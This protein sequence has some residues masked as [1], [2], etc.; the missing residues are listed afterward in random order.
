MPSN[1]SSN[2]KTQQWALLFLALGLLLFPLAGLI[3]P[4]WWWGSHHLAFLPTGLVAGFWGVA[5]G[6]I[7]VAMWKGRPFLSIPLTQPGIYTTI[8]LLVALLVGFLAYHFPLANDPYGDAFLYFPLREIGAERLDPDIFKKVFSIDFGSGQGRQALL[9][10]MTI[11]TYYTGLTYK[12][13]YMGLAIGCGTL[14]T[15]S[16]MVFARWYLKRGWPLILGIVLALG[17][18]MLQVFFGHME[19]YALAYLLLSWWGM[20]LFVYLEKGGPRVG[21]WMTFTWLLGYRFHSFFFLFLPVMILAYV[22]RWQKGKPSRQREDLG[23][24]NIKGGQDERGREGRQPSQDKESVSSLFSIGGLFKKVFLPLTGLGILVYFFALQDHTDPRTLDDFG[25]LDRLFLPIVPPE[26]PLDRYTLQSGWHLFDYLNVVLFWSL[27]AW[28]VVLGLGVVQRKKVNWKTP[29]LPFAFLA[30]IMVAAMLFMVNPL[31]S[32]AMDWDLYC[33]AVPMMVLFGFG[34]IRGRF[35]IRDGSQAAN[36][37]A[38]DSRANEDR[39]SQGT[40]GTSS[41]RSLTL[42]ALSLALFSLPFIIVN[43]NA[44][45]QSERLITTGK[46]VFKSYYLHSRRVILFGL[47]L[48]PRHPPEHLV[49]QEAIVDELRPY[50]LPEKD[51]QFNQLLTNLG[52]LAYRLN[53]DPAKGLSYYLEA[54]KYGPIRPSDAH[55]IMYAHLELGQYPEAHVRAKLL[56]KVGY[57]DRQQA[58]LHLIR[59]TLEIKDYPEAKRVVQQFLTEYPKATKMKEVIRRIDEE[60]RVDELVDMFR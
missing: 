29:G 37:P 57:P 60:D 17:T 45:A 41:A 54:E 49:R 56:L 15:F 18:P 3:S 52:N 33:F 13:A 12:E 40:H 32:M 25:N 7:G 6:L 46:Y 24:S 4:G 14:Y 30:W 34:L 43:A 27:P 26:A 31:F 48:P 10:I 1:P 55:N 28:L 39:V 58:L 11:V 59:T 35:V 16:W 9:R 8:S 21:F 51:P 20:A 23:E 50:A 36:L 38:S 53:H 42:M 2:N 22:Y 44:E 19:N 5:L 47:N